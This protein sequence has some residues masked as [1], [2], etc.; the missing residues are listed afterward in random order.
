[1]NKEETREVRSTSAE[2]RRGGV[3]Q[4]TWNGGPQVEAVRG[5]VEEK[6][7]TRSFRNQTRS[8]QRHVHQK[9]GPG[10]KEEREGAIIVRLR[11]LNNDK[12][13]GEKRTWSR[14]RA[15]T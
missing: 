7:N 8:V 3:P 11:G 2:K 1:M 5:K 9:R 12:P 15:V 6:S 13:D 4:T 14:K 10:M